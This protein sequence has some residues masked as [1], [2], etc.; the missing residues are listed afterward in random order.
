MPRLILTREQAESSYLA[1]VEL[2]NEKSYTGATCSA[3]IRFD[4]A[5]AHLHDDERVS[6]QRDT[7][8]EGAAVPPE[9]HESIY[10]FGDTYEVFK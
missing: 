4:G 3:S 10:A 9:F 1:F 6:A 2:L 5:S 7:D 8:D